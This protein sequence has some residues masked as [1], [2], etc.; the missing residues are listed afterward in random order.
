MELHVF[1]VWI[2]T[3]GPADTPAA[4]AWTRLQAGHKTQNV[5]QHLCFYHRGAAHTHANKV[6][7]LDMTRLV[8]RTPLMV[9]S[10]LGTSYP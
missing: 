2:V 9:R 1:L 8:L 10:R 5:A 4:G 6:K 7:Q 3:D